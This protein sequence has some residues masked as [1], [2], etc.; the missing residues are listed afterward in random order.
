MPHEQKHEDTALQTEVEKL[1]SEI[2]AELSA[3]VNNQKLTWA[4]PVVTIVL[5]VLVV[6]AIGQTVQAF[7][8]YNKIKSGNL[9]AGGAAPANSSIQNL[10]NMVGGC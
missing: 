4:S 6:L 1:K 7:T 8:I 9:P 5:A 2:D 3:P 10:P